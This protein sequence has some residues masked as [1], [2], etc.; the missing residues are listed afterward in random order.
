MSL[1][2]IENQADPQPLETSNTKTE[3]S[4]PKMVRGKEIK[5]PQTQQY[6]LTGVKDGKQIKE[7]TWSE[8][9]PYI[10]ENCNCSKATAWKAY[11]SVIDAENKEK[12]ILT[13]PKGSIKPSFSIADEKG[14]N[15]EF[16]SEFTSQ[17]I[18]ELPAPN[19]TQQPANLN[20]DLEYIKDMLRGAH[21]LIASKEGLLGEK[22][23]RSKDSLVLVS[24]QLFLY[25][26]KRVTPE[27]LANSDTP[28]LII[29]Y[30][31]LLFGILNDVRKD[32]EKKKNKSAESKP[33]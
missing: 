11:R 16:V 2:P 13:K 30:L 24:D 1:K 7:M 14:K 18:E 3:T 8:A 29:S 17:E 33:A 15:P 22:Y 20:M 27:Q 21:V 4:K 32:R 23:G 19:A 26:Q 25:I 6:V 5:F 9:K 12:G 28:L 10:M 31:M